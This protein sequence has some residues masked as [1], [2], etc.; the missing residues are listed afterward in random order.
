MHSTEKQF[1]Q[2]WQS[3]IELQVRPD[4]ASPALPSPSKSS[5]DRSVL[6]GSEV[7]R[8]DNDGFGLTFEQHSNGMI[9]SR[10]SSLV[11]NGSGTFTGKVV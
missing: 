9:H 2:Q 11:T 8:S 3:Q 6:L 4:D 7:L 10:P 1:Q 5:S